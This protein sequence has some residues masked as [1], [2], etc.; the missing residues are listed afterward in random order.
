VIPNEPRY[1]TTRV[2]VYKDKAFA[3]RWT[4]KARNHKIIGDSGQSYVTL[5][6]AKRAA[7]KL[8]PEAEITVKK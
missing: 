1:P 2:T 5:W 8:F 3:W 7:K 4:A 6:N